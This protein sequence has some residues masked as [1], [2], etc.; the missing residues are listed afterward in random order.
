MNKTNA[1]TIG[2]I[3]INNIEWYVPHYRASVKEQ[4]KLMEQNID[5]I[6]TEFRYVERPVFMKEVITQNLWRFELGT[7]ECVNVHLWIIVGFQQ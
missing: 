4:G 3:K 7:Q 6:P 2:K 1:T 5:K